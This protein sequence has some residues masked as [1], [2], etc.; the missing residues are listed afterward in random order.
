MA[1]Q[2]TLQHGK[3]RS[4]NLAK[5]LGIKHGTNFHV[6]DSTAGWGKDAFIMAHLG[7]SITCLERNNAMFEMLNT[8]FQMAQEHTTTHETMIRVNWQQLDAIDYLQNEHTQPDIIYIDPMFPITTKSAKVKKPMQ[9][10]QD[11]VGADNDGD[12]LLHLA[13]QRAKHRVVVKRAR[14]SALL[15]DRTPSHQLVGKSNRYDV[16]II[17]PF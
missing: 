7:Y 2:H 9:L 14:H 17:S 1:W 13:L 3:W 6:L 4:S 10:A 11:I 8:A 5:A 16:Y 15:A 12:A